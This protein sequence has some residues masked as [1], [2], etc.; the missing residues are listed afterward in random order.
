MIFMTVFEVLVA[1]GPAKMAEILTD[2]KISFGDAALKGAGLE[3]KT[4]D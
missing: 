2:A 4:S 3:H 1:A